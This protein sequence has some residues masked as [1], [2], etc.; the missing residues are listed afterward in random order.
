MSLLLKNILLK[1]ADF[2]LEVDAELTAPITGLFGPSGSGKTTLLEIIAGLRRPDEGQVVLHGR[3]LTDSR[4]HLHV[5]PAQRRVGY[6]PQDL[7]LFPHLNAG[8]N[9]HYGFRAQSSGRI[10]PDRVITVLELSTLL[11][12]P[13]HRLSGG[14]QQRIALGRALLADPQLLLL[15]EPLSSLDDRLKERIIPYFKAIHAEFK[16]PM[17]YVTHSSQ[18]LTALCDEVLYLNQGKL[19][20][21]E[22]EK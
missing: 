3:T 9:L 1:Q 7:A 18:E 2:T 15:D 8:A 22:P 14:E 19:T 6:V 16:V 4:Q 20:T 21:V 11:S 5:R 17:I 13:V 12:R 10:S